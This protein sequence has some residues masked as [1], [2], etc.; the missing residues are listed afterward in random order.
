METGRITESDWYQGH[1]KNIQWPITDK[2]SIKK[3]EQ[4]GFRPQIAEFKI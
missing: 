3:S 1:P 4:M 2:H